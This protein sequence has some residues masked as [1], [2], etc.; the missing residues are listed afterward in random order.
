M[1]DILNNVPGTDNTGDDSTILREFY[2]EFREYAKDTRD[3]H[4]NVEKYLRGGNRS[5]ADVRYRSGQADTS[6]DFRNPFGRSSSSFGRR[7]SF[8]GGE[9][10][11]FADAFEKSM[12]DALG[13]SQIKKRLKDALN[14]FAKD[15]G[16]DL[17]HLPEKFG[18]ELGRY[19]ANAF[20]NTKLGKKLTDKINDAI[21]RRFDK[22][23]E[24][25]ERGKGRTGNRSKSTRGSM[26]D[27]TRG[28]HSASESA[29]FSL[30][31]VTIFAETVTVISR[32]GGQRPSLSLPNGSSNA[33]VPIGGS[34]ALEP[35]GGVPIDFDALM[36]SGEAS[37]AIG[38]FTEALGA[39]A[40]ELMIAK[41]ALSYFSKGIEWAL[42]DFK[43]SFKKFKETLL[44]TIVRG[45][46]EL[47]ENV[48][49]QEERW[50]A[51][52]R[53][54]IEEPFNILKSAAQEVYDVWDNQLRLIT[55][56]QGYNKADLQDLMAVYA[57]RI[58]DE[59]LS[60]VVS[61]SDITGNLAKVLE[62]G[63]SG[64]VAEE[65]AYI[66]TILNA[67]IP[68]QDFFEYGE[69]YSAI[70]ANLIAG[71]M[72]QEQAIEE[73]NNQLKAFASNILYTNRELTGG[74]STGLKNASDLF[75]KSMQITQAAKTGNVAEVAGVLTSVAGITG[76]IAPD[77]ASSMVDAV[78][79]SALGGNASDI[80]A[81]RSLTGI[82]ASN[83]EFL[84]K[85]ATD[86]QSVFSTMFFNLARMQ[87]M[88]N[89][90]FMEVAE[91]LSSVF[92]ISMDAF[93]RVDFTQ[94]AKAVANMDTNS[95]ALNENMKLLASGQ[96]TTTAEQ[97]KMQQINQYMIE[98]GLAYVVDNAAARMIQEHMWDEQIARQ[99][100]EATFA[101]D[102]AG[103]SLELLASIESVGNK[104]LT[105]VSFGTSGI[106]DLN[107]TEEEFNEQRKDIARLLIQGKVGKGSSF[108]YAGYRAAFDAAVA[109]LASTGILGRDDSWAGGKSLR[110]KAED[111]GIMNRVYAEYMSSDPEFK[112]L[113]KTGEDLNLVS[114]LITLMR[115][116]SSYGGATSSPSSRYG[117]GS[118]SKSMAAG[119]LGVRRDTSAISPLTGS[120]TKQ[121]TMNLISKIDSMLTDEYL[122][123][124]IAEGGYAEWKKSASAFGISDI[125]AA[126]ESVGYKESDVANYFE[127]LQ[128]KSVAQEK[129]KLQQK[130][131][132]FWDASIQYQNQTIT[133][134][135]STK[136]SLDKF[137][138]EWVKY[139]VEHE[140]YK[141][142]L[143]F[144]E[145]DK[146][147]ND[148]TQTTED[149]IYAL[150]DT[151]TS[152]QKL[153]D[154]QL[155]TNVLLAQIVTLMQ[156]ILTNQANAPQ[157]NL[158]NTIVGLGMG[159][160]Q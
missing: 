133:L 21:N 143:D 104:L 73:A 71:G 101:V 75:T 54:M 105:V 111:F 45:T 130:E 20:R 36:G 62:S 95:N 92:G 82:N 51:D 93:A 136:E 44:K 53:T 32:G 113:I 157:L 63:L 102:L 156:S 116:T 88:S 30:K 46:E 78:V 39:V 42:D 60:R 110:D 37:A 98:E 33:L 25:Y 146:A 115:G 49:T 1:A 67:A 76:A 9:F 68:T 144:K 23:G 16:T 147:L 24:A 22:I 126:L 69:A 17:E 97:L 84:R 90:A 153:D 154:P 100:T 6:Y 4:E 152:A 121:A 8:G 148:K 66:A 40:P 118:I 31:S 123:K 3:Y 135:T 94:L 38:G 18:D 47:K 59:G 140:A 114:D 96:T 150:V 89:D 52:V 74:F 14:K 64:T 106:D 34:G 15:L 77:L 65:F 158:P 83:T 99:I 11:R 138:N 122:G 27:S 160:L 124:Y 149:A 134:I 139:F 55:A 41:A 128:I 137:Y 159:L 72:S 141:S 13:G 10:D 85:L 57:Q 29:G 28:A 125:G 5:S 48:K 70:A 112:K 86:P 129:L 103:S 79:K 132:E 43:Q 107:K 2:R 80:V 131:E 155:Q 151:L 35:S 58:R 142:A 12:L 81:L 91:G 109:D 61:G 120:G 50:M 26:F 56:T 7:G 145:V 117:W 87:N 127:N 108:D 19:A 119:L